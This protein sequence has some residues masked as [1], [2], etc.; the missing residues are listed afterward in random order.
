MIKLAFTV[1]SDGV[2]KT[3]KAEGYSSQDANILIGEFLGFSIVD[4]LGEPPEIF[5]EDAEAE[6]DNV[7][8][9]TTKSVNENHVPSD[10]HV[11]KKQSPP[12]TTKAAVK[13]ENTE[14]TKQEASKT[15][16]QTHLL[17]SERTSY[18]MSDFISKPHLKSAEG[19]APTKTS[20]DHYGNKHTDAAVDPEEYKE[21][22][23][24]T[25]DIPDA[26]YA[27]NGVLLLRT[28]LECFNCGKI[29]DRRYSGY[30]NTFIK[31]HYCGE[32]SELEPAT[33]ETQMYDGLE[34]PVMDGDAY[35][36]AFHPFEGE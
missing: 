13:E 8:S 16:K 22:K 28:Y 19:K 7:I 6:L 20:A 32:K 24:E 33:D 23:P 10:W 26:R 5:T 17:N 3:M 15:K 18:P 34:I 29:S 25:P 4:E 2:T 21:D 11:S 14:E 36:N 12:D 1:K 35:F 9:T 27:E 31:C 30:S